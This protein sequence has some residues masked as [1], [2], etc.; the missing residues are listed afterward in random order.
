MARTNVCRPEMVW[1]FRSFYVGL[2]ALCSTAPCYPGLRPGLGYGRAIGAKR[3]QHVFRHPSARCPGH[4]DYAAL[5][6]N[7]YRGLSTTLRSGRN[8]RFGGAERERSNGAHWAPP[9]E[10]CGEVGESGRASLDTPPRVGAPRRRTNTGVS[11]L[12]CAPVE[13]T[14]LGVRKESGRM[15]LTGHLRGEVVARWG[16]AVE[17]RS[18]PHPLQRAQRVGHPELGRRKGEPIQGFL[19]CAALR[20]R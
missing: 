3:R 16:R 12:R 18:I 1:A 4:P 11:P 19:H 17:L 2:T 5:E 6:E 9:W 7:Q 10:C 15:E 13:M 8:D 20:S 14:D